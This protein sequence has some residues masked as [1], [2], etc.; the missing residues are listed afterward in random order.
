MNYIAIIVTILLVMLLFFALRELMCWYWKINK[1]LNEQTKTNILLSK[2]L[3]Q[4]GGNL[5]SKLKQ[6]A[7]IEDTNTHD[8]L[9]DQGKTRNVTAKTAE[10]AGWTLVKK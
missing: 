1:I 2:I 7:E 5:E 10:K 8:Y 6:V 4:L 3:I 9:D